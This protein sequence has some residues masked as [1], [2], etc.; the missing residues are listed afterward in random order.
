MQH[1]VIRDISR[2]RRILNQDE[3]DIFFHFPPG[4][5]PSRARERYSIVSA[6]WPRVTCTRV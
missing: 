3:K 6:S 4:T 2:R 1:D 5:F